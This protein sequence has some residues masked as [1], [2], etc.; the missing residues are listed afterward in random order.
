M[1]N[2]IYINLLYIHIINKL[3]EPQGALYL[4]GRNGNLF[5]ESWMYETGIRVS[6][7]IL[8]SSSIDA[9]RMQ[10]REIR[11]KS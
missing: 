10:H 4:G 5:V 1:N 6:D 3:Q 11:K 9:A 7:F 2:I 8:V